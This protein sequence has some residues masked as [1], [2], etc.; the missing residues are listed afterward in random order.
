MERTIAA[1]AVGVGLAYGAYQLFKP[2]DARIIQSATSSVPAK[3]RDR[4]HHQDRKSTKAFVLGHQGDP[5]LADRPAGIGGD[6][7]STG[8]IQVETTKSLDETSLVGKSG[9]P[10]DTPPANDRSTAQASQAHMSS[11]DSGEPGPLGKILAGIKGDSDKMQALREHFVQHRDQ[12]VYYNHHEH[13]Q[14][15]QLFK[16]P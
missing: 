7:A 3:K 9:G 2:D 1:L 16:C 11:T 5:V 6:H 10:I 15:C 8:D 13:D 4:R 14:W 12:A